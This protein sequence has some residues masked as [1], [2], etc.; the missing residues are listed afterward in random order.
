MTFA[1][2]LANRDFRR[3]WLVGTLSSM[4]RWLDT[5]SFAIVA[6][7]QSGSPFIVAM[8]SMLRMLPMGLCG[9]LLATFADRLQRRTVFL[10]SVGLN[11]TMALSLALLSASGRLAIWHL[12]LAAFVNGISWTAENTVRRVNLGDLVGSEALPRA[13]SLDA[14]SANAAR[15]LGPTAGGLFL[16]TVGITGAFCLGATLYFVS[17]LAMLGYRYQHSQVGGASQS[18]FARL[19]EGFAL[20]RRSPKLIGTLVI[21]AIFNLW[22]WP[23]TAMVPVLAQGQLGL[24]SEA[25]GLL[26]SLDGLGALVASVL[27]GWLVTSRLH[28]VVYAVS[29]GTYGLVSIM[30][31]MSHSVLPAG[32]AIL[33]SGAASAGF[34]IMQ[35]T[36]TYL[37]APPDLRG[38]A[39]GVLAL[40]IGLAPLG[41]L[42]LGLLAD[43]T[44]S[45]TATMI[46]GAEGLLAMLLTWRWW[47]ILLPA[48][49]R[50]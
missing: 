34:G 14:A 31:A 4:V 50:V 49:T 30:L 10:A 36:L 48:R 38:R 16:A 19:V 40:C 32:L 46:V 26:V 24:G 27:V 12:A 23:I 18:I 5:L 6:Y 37:A 47:R 25:T 43:A 7:Q 29:V 1:A 45:P 9:P 15:M 39:F 2:V 42:H 35:T 3:L 8:L 21:T 22:G 33:L 17:L 44:S 28:G 41:F 13:T 20:V 11:F